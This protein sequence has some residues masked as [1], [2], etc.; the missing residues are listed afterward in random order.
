MRLHIGGQDFV[1][2]VPDVQRGDAGEIG[3]LAREE[4]LQILPAM[5]HAETAFWDPMIVTD[6]AGKAILTITMP[7]R[8]TAWRLRAKGINGETLA[9][10][11]TADVI[12]KKELFGE[13][14]L[15][16][17]F[18]VGDKANIPVEI[19]NSLDGARSIKVTLK[20]TL[21]DKST[22]QTK[23]IDVARPWHQ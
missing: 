16:M 21:G 2:T 12:T 1:R 4:G 13:M 3:H 22:E 6:G 23:T 17:A 15:P 11:A 19:H 10:E 20:A 8:S 5:A 14:K 9:G 18:T 7:D